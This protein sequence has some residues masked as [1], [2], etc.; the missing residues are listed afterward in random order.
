MNKRRLIIILSSIILLSIFSGEAIAAMC[1]PTAVP[2]PSITEIIPVVISETPIPLATPSATPIPSVNQN[3]VSTIG[4]TT[5]SSTMM[6]PASATCTIP[7]AKPIITAV[8]PIGNGSVEVHWLESDQN[9]TKYS[10][11]YGV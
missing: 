8:T 10:L 11:T 2:D 5:Q 3:E 6:P 9:I 4:D 1:S 7:F